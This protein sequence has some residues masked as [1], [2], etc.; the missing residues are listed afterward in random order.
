MRP[1]LVG[2][3]NEVVNEASVTEPIVGDGTR[4]RSDECDIN[5]RLAVA[6]GT[7]V[8]LADKHQ[9]GKRSAYDHEPIHLLTT[10]SLRT[11]NARYPEGRFAS[12]RFR[13][14][15]VIDTD[16]RDGF[17]EQGRVERRLRVGEIVVDERCK[18]SVMTTL[19]QGGLP[20][21][22]AILKTVTAH[23]AE[24][25]GVYATVVRTGPVRVGDPVHLIT[26]KQP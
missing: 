19:R 3:Q 17:V 7:A 15:I 20:R 11:F 21:D 4:R 6:F 22:P 8:H 9:E 2:E 24:Q 18:R 12:A 5:A 16:T 25:A 10:A 23:N 1:Q 13:P 26:S 14:N